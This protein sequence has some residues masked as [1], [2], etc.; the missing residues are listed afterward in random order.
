MTKRGFWNQLNWIA[1]DRIPSFR[2]WGSIHYAVH[3]DRATFSEALGMWAQAKRDAGKDDGIFGPMTVAES[4]FALLAEK[5]M[6]ESEERICVNG[7]CV[8][9]WYRG[10]NT[11]G[12]GP[13]GCGC[14]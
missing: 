3:N 2:K 13:A 1:Y 12:A 10:R 7:N 11:G 9:Y 6:D 8:E 5:T 14:C 4:F